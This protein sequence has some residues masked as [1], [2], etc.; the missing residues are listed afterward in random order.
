MPVARS[1]C[2]DLRYLGI[3]DFM[4]TAKKTLLVRAYELPPTVD[5]EFF[6]GISS[7]VAAYE[8]YNDS[9]RFAELE[10]RNPTA[11]TPFNLGSRVTAVRA[12]SAGA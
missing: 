10:T 2:D 6:G 11:Q 5:Y 1:T 4:A 8:I 3:R 9:T 12:S 7:L